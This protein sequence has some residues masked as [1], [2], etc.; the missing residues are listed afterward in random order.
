MFP[1]LLRIICIVVGAIN[2]RKK[3]LCNAQYYYMVD[4]DM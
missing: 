1:E 2:Y 3:L 4:S